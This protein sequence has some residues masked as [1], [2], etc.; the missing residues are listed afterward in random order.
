MEQQ[1]FSQNFRRYLWLRRQRVKKVTVCVDDEIARR[2]DCHL[3]Y[4]ELLMVGDWD[5]DPFQRVP[6]AVVA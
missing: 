4:R 2:P 6:R 5:N 3:D 1:Y